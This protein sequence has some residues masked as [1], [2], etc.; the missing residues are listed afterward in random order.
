MTAQDMDLGHFFNH[1]EHESSSIYRP[2]GS[3]TALCGGSCITRWEEL[4]FFA[5][6]LWRIG[7]GKAD[8][9][10]QGEG[11][12]VPESEKRGENSQQMKLLHMISSHDSHVIALE[13]CRSS[14]T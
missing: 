7:V 10:Q 13:P 3:G 6:S 11:R 2:F 4:D 5:I 9:R 8:E 14:K 12:A 1:K